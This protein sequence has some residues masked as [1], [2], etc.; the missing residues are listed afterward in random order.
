ME[1][2]HAIVTSLMGQ[3]QSDVYHFRPLVA[4][5]FVGRTG[6]V[7]G[8]N[9]CIIQT[10]WYCVHFIRAALCVLE[11]VRFI[12]VQR[13]AFF[14]VAKSAQAGSILTVYGAPSFF[15]VSASC[16]ASCLDAGNVVRDLFEEALLQRADASFR[17]VVRDGLLPT[18]DVPCPV[19]ALAKTSGLIPSSLATHPGMWSVEIAP[20]DYVVR[21]HAAA[22]TPCRAQGAPLFSELAFLSRDLVFPGY[23][24]GLVLTDRFARVTNEEHDY[25]LCLFESASGPAWASIRA[26]IRLGNAHDVLDNVSTLK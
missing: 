12:S 23:P 20:G 1:H 9:A 26:G 10:P 11:G 19:I 16:T 22:Y 17:F 4:Q 21:L 3:P 15:S 5:P 2:V 24:S 7:D 18:V 14:L 8:G 13:F 6:Y 25:L